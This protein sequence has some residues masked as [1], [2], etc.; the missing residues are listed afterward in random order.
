MKHSLELEFSD[1]CYTITAAKINGRKILN[2]NSCYALTRILQMVTD[3]AGERS[4]LLDFVEDAA[5]TALTSPH[6]TSKRAR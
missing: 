3:G 6:K 1:N 4:A 2:P 5:N